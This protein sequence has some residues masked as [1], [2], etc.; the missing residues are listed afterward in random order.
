MSFSHHPSCKI[1]HSKRAKHILLR[2]TA[3]DGLVATLPR[4][5]NRKAL[6]RALLEHADW[7]EKQTI[8]VSRDRERLLLARHTRP[9]ELEFR[10]RGQSLQL[11]YQTT[12]GS[13][14]RIISRGNELHINTPDIGDIETIHQQLSNYIRREAKQFLGK[15]LELLSERHG[16]RY[17]GLSIRR[18]KTRWG[19]CSARHRINL[20]DKLLFL[21]EPLMEHVLLHELAHTRHLNH[22][23]RFHALLRDL[24]PET[25]QHRNALRH[26]NQYI[27]AWL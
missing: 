9:E 14:S 13:R 22:S 20:N 12:S 2:V 27:P 23:P 17:T 8:R 16:L 6:D 1:R 5:A 4:G 26:A 7:I 18:Q 11:H 10:A 15:R 25:S 21:P 24:D 3:E 19:S